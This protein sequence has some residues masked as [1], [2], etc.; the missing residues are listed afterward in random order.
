MS[1]AGVCEDMCEQLVRTAGC[2]WAR[3]RCSSQAPSQ[4][5]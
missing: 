3:N 5:T 2:R 4:T 1:S